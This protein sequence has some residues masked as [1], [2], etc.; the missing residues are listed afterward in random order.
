MEELDRDPTK[1][2]RREALRKAV[3]VGAVVWAVPA[4]QTVAATKAAADQLGSPESQ[5]PEGGGGSGGG[6]EVPDDEKKKKKKKHKKHGHKGD[7]KDKGKGGP[8]E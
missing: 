7:N 5:P 1:L 4:I 8:D 3:T 2:T 6:S